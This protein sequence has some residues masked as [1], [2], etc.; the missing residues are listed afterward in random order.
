MSACVTACVTVTVV[1]THEDECAGAG[2]EVHSLIVCSGRNT[3]TS[4]NRRTRVVS[5]EA[6]AVQYQQQEE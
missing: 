2:D 4:V 6:R 5:T 3:N 1:R